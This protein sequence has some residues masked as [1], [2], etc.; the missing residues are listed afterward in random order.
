M[1]QTHCKLAAIFAEV[2][3]LRRRPP[4]F[5]GISFPCYEYQ[6]IL[7]LMP[8]FARRCESKCVVGRVRVSVGWVQ[9]RSRGMQVR[10]TR[11]CALLQ[12]QRSP[13][14][15]LTCGLARCLRCESLLRMAR[16]LLASSA[17]V[18]AEHIFES[19]RGPQKAHTITFVHSPSGPSNISE[20]VF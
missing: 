19:L 2:A 15:G 6:G 14:H 17:V 8:P 11:N 16:T 5:G 20:N 10:P 7:L 4:F 18:L 12:D 1:L 13:V 3:E 9:G